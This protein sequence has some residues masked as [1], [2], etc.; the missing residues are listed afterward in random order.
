MFKAI[1]LLGCARDGT[2]SFLPS[3]DAIGLSSQ[4]F[5]QA[6]DF[7]CDTSIE[8]SEV[9]KSPRI[10]TD[11]PLKAMRSVALVIFVESVDASIKLAFLKASA[12]LLRHSRTAASALPLIA[13]KDPLL[14]K[15]LEQMESGTR[16]LR[17]A[18]G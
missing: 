16:S 11:A 10:F 9:Q 15:I 14:E 2:L 7:T 12:R 4:P 5:C 6:C 18:A 3:S 8:H 17:M 13:G 1:G